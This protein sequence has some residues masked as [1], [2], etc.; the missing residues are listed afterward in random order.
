MNDHQKE[1]ALRIA[2]YLENRLSPEERESFKRSL[3]EDDE[4]RLQY[5]DALMNRAGTEQSSGASGGRVMEGEDNAGE[6][7]A[8]DGPA[9]EPG[10]SAAGA[11][12]GDGAHAAGGVTDIG[13]ADASKPDA[14]GGVEAANEPGDAPGEES[15]EANEGGE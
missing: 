1:N 11:G 4:L 2:L 10:G 3:S 15:Q 6:A 9:A 7:M 12:W 8:E 5:V 13:A 14:A